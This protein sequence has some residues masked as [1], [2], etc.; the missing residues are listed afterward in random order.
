MP[1]NTDK[2]DNTQVCSYALEKG[3]Q[4]MTDFS[5]FTVLKGSI[6]KTPCFFQNLHISIFFATFLTKPER[7]VAKARSAEPA[8]VGFGK[9]MGELFQ[10]SN[11]FWNSPMK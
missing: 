11:P 6:F 7:A 8:R 3:G 5:N 4:G 9:K 1:E 10:G 2:V